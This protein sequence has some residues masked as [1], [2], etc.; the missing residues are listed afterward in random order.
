MKEPSAMSSNQSIQNLIHD[1]GQ[2]KDA[3]VANFGRCL[4]AFIETGDILWV[5]RV[6]APPSYRKIYD[7]GSLVFANG[8]P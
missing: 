6:V 7:L 5:G 3:A 4:S 2:Q 8:N 1:I